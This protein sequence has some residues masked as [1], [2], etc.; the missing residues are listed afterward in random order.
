MSRGRVIVG[1]ACAVALALLAF[2]FTSDSSPLSALR[3]RVL[4][5]SGPA[6]QGGWSAGGLQGP[7]GGSSRYEPDAGLF[8][9]DRPPVAILLSPARAESGVDTATGVLEGR[10]IAWGSGV[11]LKPS[12]SES[13]RRSASHFSLVSPVR[14]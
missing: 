9:A 5:G 8:A 6:G 3:D 7:D 13:S 12:N 4:A 11:G 14:I 10:V 2:L 1:V